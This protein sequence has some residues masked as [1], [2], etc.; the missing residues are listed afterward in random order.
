MTQSH[1]GPAGTLHARATP[2][3]GVVSFRASFPVRPDLVAGEDVLARLVVRLLDKGTA[4]R[5]RFALADALERVGASLAFYDDGLRIGFQ[6]RALRDDVDDVLALAAE[7]IVEPAFDLEEVGKAK[8]WLDAAVRESEEDTGDQADALLARAVYAPGHP[9]YAEPFEAE[10]A[11]LAAYAREHVTAF[12]SAHFPHGPLTLVL[13]GDVDGLPFDALLG[14]FGARAAVDAS[15]ALPAAKREVP[16]ASRKRLEEKTSADVR[17]GHGLSLRRTDADYLAFR[18]AVFAL[19]GNFSARLMQSVR[20]VQGLTYGIGAAIYGVEPDHDGH[21]DIHVTLSPVNLERGIAATRSEIA[22][23]VD[24]GVSADELDEKKTTLA[25]THRVGLSTSG[26]T[27]GAILNAVEQGFGPDYVDTF[28]DRV[29][30][31]TPDAVN[32]ALR[33]HLRPEGLHEAVAGTF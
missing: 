28:A 5:T 20:D 33:T 27:A 3:P 25:G 11:R 7:M 21:V 26:G 12:H 17:L 9:N 19:G 24:E 1:S 23:L 29:R 8:A 4:H 6:G 22:R 15:G 30:A 31:L 10:R 16:G 13:A 2:A 18:A 14:R 32:A